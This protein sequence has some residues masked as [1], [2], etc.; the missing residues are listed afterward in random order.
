[1]TDTHRILQFLTWSLI[2]EVSGF[3]SLIVIA[4]VDTSED[5]LP[6][7]IVCAL[8]IFAA[9]PPFYI[10]LGILAKRLGR[11]WITWVGLTFITKPIGPFVAYFKIRNL[12][13]DS[14]K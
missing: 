4:I 9:T 12:V 10:C 5:L 8:A 7:K 6:L 14:R 13:A 11:S 3:V 1:M 2:V